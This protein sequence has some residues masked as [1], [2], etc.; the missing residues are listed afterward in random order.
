MC[1]TRIKV[2][3]T[4]W[5]QHTPINICDAVDMKAATTFFQGGMP[6]PGLFPGV[7]RRQKICLQ[8]YNEDV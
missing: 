1:F 4:T 7:S 2:K 5:L 8:T 3:F 6:A